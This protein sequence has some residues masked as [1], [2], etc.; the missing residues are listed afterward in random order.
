MTR[1]QMIIIGLIIG[2]IPGG[3]QS[4]PEQQQPENIMKNQLQVGDLIPSFELQNQSGDWVKSSD[5]IGEKVLVIFFYP[6]DDTPGCTKEACRFRDDYQDFMDLGAEVIGVSSDSVNDHARFAEKYQLP[7][8]LLSDPG[9]ILRKA[10]GVPTNLLGLLPGRVTYIIDLDGRI[11][12]MYNS[13]MNAVQHV[14]EALQV[15]RDLQVR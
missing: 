3:C 5:L 10:F 6:K 7:F 15:I 1:I 11:A 2:F 12:G 9:G 13:Q 8:T 14:E 4:Q